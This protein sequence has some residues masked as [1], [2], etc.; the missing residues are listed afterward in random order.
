[1][2]Q[3]YSYVVGIVALL[4]GLFPY[5]L[6]YHFALNMSCFKAFFEPQRIPKVLACGIKFHPATT[7]YHVDLMP[8]IIFLMSGSEYCDILCHQHFVQMDLAGTSEYTR[9]WIDQDLR[10]S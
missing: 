5:L 4:N 9:N 3:C 8:N 10:S 1:M 7:Q 6:G 2:C